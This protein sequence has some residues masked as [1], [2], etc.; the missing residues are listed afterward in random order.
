MATCTTYKQEES[1]ALVMAPLLN[2]HKDEKDLSGN[3][4]KT[5]NMNSARHSLHNMMIQLFNA[6][7]KCIIKR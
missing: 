5:F 3:I 6:T 1:S 4:E 2:S 7:L